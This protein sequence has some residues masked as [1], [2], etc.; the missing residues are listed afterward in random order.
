MLTEK[1]RK[2]T[3]SPEQGSCVE[4]RTCDCGGVQVRDTKDHGT[5]PVLNFTADS[6]RAFIGAVPVLD[7]TRRSRMSL[8]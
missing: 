4:S 7:E 3:Y 2:S 1:W 6:W 5:G 8:R